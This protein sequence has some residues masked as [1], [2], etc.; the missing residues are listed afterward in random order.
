MITRET[1]RELAA[2]ESP[3]N[4][5]ITFYYQP[6][7]PKDKSHR[8]ESILV[9]DLVREALRDAERDG[10]KN[11]CARRDLRRVME[12]AEGLHGNG[13]R[14]KAI[15]A[16][17]KQGVWREVDLPPSLAGTQLIVN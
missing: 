5:A 9:K 15:F 3:E 17:E 10:G 8:E 4:C 7:M 11:E 2:F 12:V 1:I 14:A 16:D 6:P 13:R